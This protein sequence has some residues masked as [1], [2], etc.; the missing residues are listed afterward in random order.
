MKEYQS[1]KMEKV[2][3]LEQDV[4]TASSEGGL[5]VGGD[6][7]VGSNNNPIEW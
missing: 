6:N 5:V 3:F 7:G 1:P 2:M 4:V